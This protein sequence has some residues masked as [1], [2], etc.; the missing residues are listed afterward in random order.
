MMMMT[1]MMGY[2]KVVL[3]FNVTA[4]AARRHH[5]KLRLG[6]GAKSCFPTV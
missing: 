4:A 3:Q 5:I 1:F 6:L 2:K